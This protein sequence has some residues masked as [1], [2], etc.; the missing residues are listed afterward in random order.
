MSAE[1]EIRRRIGQCGAIT[2]A[3]FME[4]ALYWPEGGYYVTR[5]SIGA[6]G[7][8]YTSPRVHPVFGALIALQLF[9]MWRLLDEPDPF[10]VVELGAGNGLLCRDIIAA[11]GELP[12][13]FSR[14][15]NYVCLDRRNSKG[16]ESAP[17][18]SAAFASVSRLAAAG[19]P[20]RSIVGCLISNEYFDAF[21]V[22]Q[23][24]MVEGRLSEIYVYQSDGE[25]VAKT[26]ELS[27]P[28]LE[29]RFKEMDVVF[30]EGQT[31]EVNL[32]L[33]GWAQEV[34]QA[35]ESGF[36]LTIDYGD[37]ASQL[38]S[39]EK[40]FRGTLTTFQNHVQIDSPLRH[41]GH[42]DI[43]AQVDF[44]TLVDAGRRYGI[45]TLG[46]TSQ[47]QFLGQ[48]GLPG[49]RQR[50]RRMNL[51]QNAAEANRA[52]MLDLAR[53]GGLGDFKVLAQGKGVG[54][55]DLWGF[56]QSATV[57]ERV[58]DLVEEMP[59]PLLTDQHLSLLQGRYPSGAF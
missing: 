53:P 50:L 12:P 24:T 25:L 48:L 4:L 1:A 56:N 52:G 32:A 54:Q 44:T 33:E 42:Q 29:A 15:L 59:V 19:I 45:E 5:D 6:S 18:G 40:R 21:P 39:A 23:V 49:I 7:D 36:I 2:F 57:D 3:E 14:S 11:A 27:D 8:F 47:A 28:A 37:P 31:A 9:Q 41:V 43:T 38:Y 26:G 17:D 51:P 34:D 22:H 55:A 10:T 13:P 30:K 16:V 20:F 58:S 46:F 35:L